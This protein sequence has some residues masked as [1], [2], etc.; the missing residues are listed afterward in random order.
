MFL[1]RLEYALINCFII[2]NLLLVVCTLVETFNVPDNEIFKYIPT[3]QHVDT[4]LG[5]LYK[6][7]CGL[8]I[9]EFKD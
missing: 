9:S 4:L 7:V 3:L 5:E 8:F 1:W 2:Y 6:D